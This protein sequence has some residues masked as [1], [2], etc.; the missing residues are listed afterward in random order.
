M[1]FSSAVVE[2]VYSTGNRPASVHYPTQWLPIYNLQS[3]QQGSQNLIFIYLFFLN[4]GITNFGACTAAS[5]EQ[6]VTVIGATVSAFPWLSNYCYSM[7]VKQLSFLPS[8]N[9]LLKMHSSVTEKYSKGKERDCSV[10]W[11]I[12]WW[13]GWLI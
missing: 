9:L 6:M 10:N 12:D 8:Q 1:A 5:L 13:A 4:S 7:G 2:G 11:L 3:V